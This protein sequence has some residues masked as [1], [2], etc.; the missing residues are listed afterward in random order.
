M[1]QARDLNWYQLKAK[2]AYH[3]SG[4]YGLQNN[5]YYDSDGKTEKEATLLTDV[6]GCWDLINEN[7]YMALKNFH[8]K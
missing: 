8:T 2:Y 7:L 3:K 6:S 4:E 5:D 1:S